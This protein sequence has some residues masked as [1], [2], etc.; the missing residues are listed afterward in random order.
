MSDAELKTQALFSSMSVATGLAALTGTSLKEMKRLIELA[1]YKELRRRSMK[2]REV[3]KLMNVSMSTVGLLSQK[4]KAHFAAP[5]EQ[6]GLPRRVLALL[7]SGPLSANRIARA[8]ADTSEGEVQQVL[9]DLLEAGDVEEQR[10]PKVV[11]YAPTSASYRRVASGW[12]AR[13][14]GL[15]NLMR[16]VG[17]V[18]QS[19]FLDGDERAFARTLRFRIKPEELPRVREAYEKLYLDLAKL[20][21]DA[22]DDPAALAVTLS[23]LFGPERTD[24]EDS[25]S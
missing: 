13:V 19:R 12:M 22:G 4:L 17:T 10:G 20:D 15:N 16:S 11:R 7:W 6:R 1:Y 25:Q 5:E 14:D 23:Y 24:P 2:M 21:E 3:R 9:S 18:I 8:L